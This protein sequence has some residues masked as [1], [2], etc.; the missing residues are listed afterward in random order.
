VAGAAAKAGGSVPESTGSRRSSVLSLIS[1]GVAACACA[2]CVGGRRARA[3]AL[4]RDANGNVKKPTIIQQG[5]EPGNKEQQINNQTKRALFSRMVRGLPRGRDA[6]IVEVGMGEFADSVHLD[7]AWDVAMDIIGIEPNINDHRLAVQ[8]AEQAGLL[9]R[10]N[11]T[12]RLVEGVAEELPLE[13]ESV[14]A[15]VF[16]FTLCTVDDPVKAVAEARRV[17]R[18]GGQMAFLEHVLSDDDPAMA[19]QQKARSADVGGRGCHLDRPTLRT[20]EAAGFKNVDV[21]KFEV[22][23]AGLRSP[24]IVGIATA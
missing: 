18:P 19:E 12:L 17:L 9:S 7:D 8:S 11:V 3:A 10:S 13:S 21:A 22:K 23:N 6:T 1:A 4:L 2:A 14:D 16:T 5:M 15:V 24:H 20:I